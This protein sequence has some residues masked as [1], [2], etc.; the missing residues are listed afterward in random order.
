MSS[1]TILNIKLG[2][3]EKPIDVEW[4]LETIENFFEKDLSSDLFLPRPN[5]SLIEKIEHFLA[6][7][8]KEDRNALSPI[9]FLVL[10]ILYR[11]NCTHGLIIEATRGTLPVGAGLGSSAAFCCAISAALLSCRDRNTNDTLTSEKLEEINSWAFAAE[12][13]LQ[14]TPS[15]IDNTVST[16]G[17]ALSFVKQ[18]QKS[19]IRRF[20]ECPAIKLLITNTRIPRESK[21]LIRRVYDL[22][23]ATP[24][25]YN[26]LFESISCISKHFRE[27]A[28]L[29]QPCDL[30]QLVRLNQHLLRC[31][32][33]S[34][35]A[36]ES[37]CRI[38]DQYDIA[39]KLTGA[40]GGGCT[41]SILPESSSDE[42]KKALEA[43]GFECYSTSI[44]GPG[45]QI[46][47]SQY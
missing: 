14:G 23:M 36:I 28:E 44:G 18:D 46:H 37:V 17:G 12:V 22:Q 34:H 38:A 45:V 35:P 24:S 43:E 5:P 31:L 3:L 2:D 27:C 26:Q 7:Y 39:T 29:K 10:G 11:E 19:I 21:V 13:I 6:C 25:V 47:V 32:D 8:T 41:I 16:F 20:D 40:G 30:K 1:P 9:L 42:L 33:V 4:K 15:G